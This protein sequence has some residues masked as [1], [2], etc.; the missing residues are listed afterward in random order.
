MGSENKTYWLKLVCLNAVQYTIYL[1]YALVTV[2]TATFYVIVMALFSTHRNSLERVRRLI[3][4][5]AMGLSF[6]TLPFVRVCYKSSSKNDKRKPCIYI[7]N[8]RSFL[9]GFLVAHPCWRH[10]SV[11]VV[12]IW[13]FRIPIIG[14]IAKIAGYL[15][16]NSMPF[17]KFSLM[18]KKMIGE[19]VS[20]VSFPEGTRSKDKTMGPFHSSMFR[21]ALQARCP[22][23]PICIFGNEIVL[24]RGNIMLRS[25]VIKI[26][27]LPAI[28]WQDY[29]NMNPYV[30]K[31][32][33][34]DIMVKELISME[35][36]RVWT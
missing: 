6:L 15:N 28:E 34:R 12:N 19:G 2:P 33:V 32:M 1:L 11:Q 10:E 20:I 22:I 5:W 36:A 35:M 24:R 23:V 31:N 27:E 13:P 30:L 7:C 17:E 21:I 18:T 8:H 16:V 9:D 14:A 26:H 3:G 25:G 4:F 29:K